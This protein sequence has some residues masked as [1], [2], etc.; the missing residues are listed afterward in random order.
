LSKLPL[1][2]QCQLSLYLHHRHYLLL[3]YHPFP[4]WKRQVYYEEETNYDDDDIVPSLLDD[5]ELLDL[6]HEAPVFSDS[7]ELVKVPAI[8][9]VSTLPLLPHHS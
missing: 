8:T 7:V 4:V 6:E 3:E 2:R 5:Y 1:R 9:V